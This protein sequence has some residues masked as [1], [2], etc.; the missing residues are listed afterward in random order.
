MTLERPAAPVS[1]A[2]HARTVVARAETDAQGYL[3]DTDGALAKLSL[4]SAVL[5]LGSVLLTYGFGAYFG[6]FPGQ[7]VA[8]VLLVYGF[9]ATVLG[10]ALKYAELAPVTLRSQPEAV[11][12]R[13]AQATETQNQVRADC[14]RYRFGDEQHLDEALEKLFTFNRPMGI[15]RRLS[16][17]LVGLREEVRGGKYTL[18]MEFTAKDKLL[19][20]E[21][22]KRTQKFTTFFGPGIHAVMEKTAQGMDVALVCGEDPTAPA[23][24]APA[25]A[26]KAEAKSE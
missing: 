2:L 3:I 6:L 19:E 9:P 25:E 15:P 18:V 23:E 4:A 10:F 21:W 17:T 8:A 12:L 22:T 24:G 5:P 20:E 26:E 16:P 1:P 14:C 11:G 7:D 13:E